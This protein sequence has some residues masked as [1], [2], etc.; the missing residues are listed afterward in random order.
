M[1]RAETAAPGMDVARAAPTGAAAHRAPV[2]VVA[3]V[4]R[5]RGG[6]GP[7]QGTTR[8]ARVVPATQGDSAPVVPSRPGVAP[9]RGAVTRLVDLARKAVDMRHGT[10]ATDKV[11]VRRVI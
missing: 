6:P 9:P 11:N 4:P 1:A 7:T 5:A 3:P 8:A 2:T 10:I